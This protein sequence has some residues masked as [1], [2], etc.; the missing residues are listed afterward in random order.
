MRSEKQR[1]LKGKKKKSKRLNARKIY[2]AKEQHY[3]AA[4][5]VLPG[6]TWHTG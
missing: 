5:T 3:P 6:G 2:L 4:H 1:V